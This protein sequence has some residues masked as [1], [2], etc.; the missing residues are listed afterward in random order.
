MLRPRPVR[1]VL[2]TRGPASARN[3]AAVRPNLSMDRRI[4]YQRYAA[5]NDVPSFRLDVER[6]W[7][8]HPGLGN[9]RLR[10]YKAT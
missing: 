2:L 3:A 4:R 10:G 1:G 9:P 7:V 6:T 5:W 8:R